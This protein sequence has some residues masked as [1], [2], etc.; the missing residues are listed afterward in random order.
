MAKQKSV[1]SRFR[2]LAARVAKLEA[3]A[4]PAPPAKNGK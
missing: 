1:V 2:D 4:K 3:A